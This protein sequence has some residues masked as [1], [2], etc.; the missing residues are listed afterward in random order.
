MLEDI[1]LFAAI[2]FTA[3][4]VDGAVGMA[5]GMTAT[6][7][8]VSFGIPPAMA[9][10]SVHAAEVVTTGAS[11]LAHCRYGNVRWPLVLRLAV[12]GMLGGVLGA[13]LLV[14]MPVQVIRPIV[15]VYL[16]VLSMVMLWKALRPRP[17]ASPIRQG[18]VV[19]GAAG[20]FLDAIGGGGWGPIV[21]STLIGRGD[22]PRFTI[23]SVNMAEFFVT[24]AVSA[25]FASSIGLDLWHVILGLIAGGILAAPFAALITRKVPDRP[26]MFIVAGVVCLLSLRNLAVDFAAA[27]P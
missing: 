18:V 13:F 2:G 15:S 25:A 1:L 19:L 23:G 10:A 7:A 26:L 17:A 8:M 21:A 5:Y 11:G 3:Q 20:G 9:S 12:P 16:L 24:A 6:S 22:V 14:A 4:M 27:F